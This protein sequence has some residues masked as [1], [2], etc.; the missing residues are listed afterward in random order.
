[1]VRLHIIQVPYLG[2][3]TE[4][5]A[6]W[7]QSYRF[8][9]ESQASSGKTLPF[10]DNL[11]QNPPLVWGSWRVGKRSAVGR[12]AAPAEGPEAR[13]EH[14]VSTTGLPGKSL[15]VVCVLDWRSLELLCKSISVRS[16]WRSR[17]QLRD[18]PRNV[19]RSLSIMA[20]PRL[21]MRSRSEKQP[22]SQ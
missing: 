21:S 20:G 3:S 14:G 22:R 12:Q 7:R 5:F 13:R 10:G 9:T 6:I 15:R 19:S 1:M 8:E 16:C 2:K 18:S 4:N 17:G 11:W